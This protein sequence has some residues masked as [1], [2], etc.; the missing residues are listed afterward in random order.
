MYSG[1]DGLAGG[2]SV[3]NILSNETLNNSTTVQSPKETPKFPDF[4]SIL[5]GW[6]DGDACA[7]AK[8]NTTAG[9]E[10]NTTLIS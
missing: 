6:E 5:R 7:D 2:I 4:T 10:L 3:V 8:V 9:H 1:N